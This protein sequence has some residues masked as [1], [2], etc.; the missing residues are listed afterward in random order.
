MAER[1]LLTPEVMAYLGKQAEPVSQKA[2]QGAILQW[3]RAVFNENR[4]HK[5]QAA[6]KRSPRRGLVAHPTFVTSLCK[7]AFVKGAPSVR[8]PIDCQ[9]GFNG[10]DEFE[11]LAPVRP[12]DT[13]TRAVRV[14]DIREK[15]SRH[16]YLAF[17]TYEST[18]T[19]QRGQVVLRERWTSDHY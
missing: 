18:F 17:V 16:G 1:S 2:E 8:P 15:Q 7:Q 10:S 3:D 12:G 6:A 14:A 5:D 11:F 9:R 13:V 19:N 4:L